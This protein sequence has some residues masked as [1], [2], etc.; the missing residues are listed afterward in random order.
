MLSIIANAKYSAYIRPIF[1]VLF[2]LKLENTL[3]VLK[4][5]YR[6]CYIQLPHDFQRLY[7]I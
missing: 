2:F 6:H 7:Y 1:K 3:N 5:Y 4:I